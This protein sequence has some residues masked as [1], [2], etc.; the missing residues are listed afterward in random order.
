MGT[1]EHSGPSTVVFGD[2]RLFEGLD[3]YGLANIDRNQEACGDDVCRRI[4]G[5]FDPY[6]PDSRAR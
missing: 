2:N 3:R 1:W 5:R 6:G 4:A